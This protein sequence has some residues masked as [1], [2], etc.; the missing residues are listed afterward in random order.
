[1]AKQMLDIATAK[2]VDNA[3]GNYI[4]RTY[5]GHAW[6]VDDYEFQNKKGETGRQYGVRDWSRANLNFEVVTRDGKA[7][8]QPIDHNKAPIHD[9][10]QQRMDEGYKA[11]VRTKKGLFRKPIRK[12]EVKLVQF[13]LGGNRKR[14]HEMAFDRQVVIGKKGIGLNGDVRRK[15]DIEQWA[16]D[17]HAFLAKKYGAENI[18]QFVV[19][20][21]ET[22]PHIHVAMVPLTREGKLSYTELFGGSREQAAAQD[23]SFQQAKSNYAKQLHTDFFDEVGK[24]WGLD[25]GDSIE[26]TGAVHLSTE[27]SIRI[28]QQLQKQNQELQ[29]QKDGLIF[30]LAA[31]QKQVGELQGE[32]AEK[33]SERIFG[34]NLSK[35]WW[36]RERG[37]QSFMLSMEIE[38]L[39]KQI[40]VNG[41]PAP[42][43]KEVGDDRLKLLEKIWT[44][45]IQIPDM[46]RKALGLGR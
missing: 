27:E 10:W 20:L 7:M 14:L 9:R 41:V 33:R 38:G 42:I 23:I 35:F 29:A 8:V 18:I 4:D 25:R 12:T 43:K 13:A 39:K 24:K 6:T 17:C 28:K 34:A 22:N 45:V 1:M 2:T 5:Q 11:V 30:D 36:N 16:L 44:H 15:K 31:L 21:D 32:V 26:E 46:A 19:H 37:Q 40:H 3:L